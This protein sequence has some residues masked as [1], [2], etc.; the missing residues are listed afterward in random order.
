MRTLTTGKKWITDR[1]LLS[2]LNFVIEDLLNEA[3]QQ[4]KIKPFVK[5]VDDI[6]TTFPKGCIPRAIEIMLNSIEPSIQFTVEQEQ[7]GH[8]AFLELKIIRNGQ[9]LMFDLYR[10]KHSLEPLTKL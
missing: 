5:Y 10:K 4:F 6:M 2:R 7:D 9:K 1:E 8:I 3:N